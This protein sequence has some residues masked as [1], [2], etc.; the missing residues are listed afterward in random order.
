[1]TL[2]IRAAR[3]P[4]LHDVAAGTAPTDAVNVQ[5]LNDGLASTLASANAYTDRRVSALEFDLASARREANAGTAGALAAA[6]LPQAF[7]PVA[8]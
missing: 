3:P 5:Q 7:E 6:G 8:A 2:R 4:A 1:M